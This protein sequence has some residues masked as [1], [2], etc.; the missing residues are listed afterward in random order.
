M[1]T[2][3]VSATERFFELGSLRGV[4]TRRGGFSQFCLW[5]VSGWSDY[6]A[7]RDDFF[8]SGVLWRVGGLCCESGSSVL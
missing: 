3:A 4:N 8:W 1:A 7:G 5:R 2:V 6:A